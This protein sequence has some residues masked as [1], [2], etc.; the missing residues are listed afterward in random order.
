MNPLTLFSALALLF[1][2]GATAAQETRTTYGDAMRWYQ[3]AAETGS[4]GAQ[5]LL[6]QLFEAGV[7]RTQDPAAAAAWYRKAAVQGHRLAQYKLG[8]MYFAANGVPRDAAK[9]AVW[10]RKAA[11]QGLAEAQFNLGGLYD[12]GTGVGASRDQAANWYRKAA[13]QGNIRAR[14]NLGL[15]LAGIGGAKFKPVDPVEA[16]VWL[17]L[18]ADT[19]EGDAA[20]ARDQ[21]AKG[22]TAAEK[23]DARNRLEALRKD[24]GAKEG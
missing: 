14:L 6:G 5:F 24:A 13:V 11:E 23:E 3:R 22:L 15:L 20:A 16:W 8:L 18:A 2:A 4:P 7:G 19:G 17:S 10:Y 1:L 12:R 21:V 9:A